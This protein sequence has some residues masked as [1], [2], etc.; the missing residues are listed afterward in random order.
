MNK[1]KRATGLIMALAVS[2]ATR[3]VAA[4]LVS[5]ADWES[6]SEH[7]L[8]LAQSAFDISKLRL[9]ESETQRGESPC[10]LSLYA[11]VELMRAEFEQLQ[12]ALRVGSDLK[13][14]EAEP[15]VSHDVAFG[16][17]SALLK[18]KSDAAA[19]SLLGMRCDADPRVL[20]H[21]AELKRIA[22]AISASATSI[23]GRMHAP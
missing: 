19:L 10:L 23:L 18:F 8:P 5:Q 13:H 11:R 16:T 7:E 22:A 2:V 20:R 3:G 12:A 17:R 14:P 4:P 1:Q 9:A 21:V 15:G 6:L